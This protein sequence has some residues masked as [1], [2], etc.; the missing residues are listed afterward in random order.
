MIEIKF[1]SKRSMVT[2]CIK[3][4]NDLDIRTRAQTRI[5]IRLV[6]MYLLNVPSVSSPYFSKIKL[7]SHLGKWPTLSLEI[8]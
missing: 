7:A 8:P 3:I 4:K 1:H 2:S 5:Q 6:Y